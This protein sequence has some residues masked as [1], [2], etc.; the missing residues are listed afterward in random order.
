ML[1]VLDWKESGRLH[2]RF[3]TLP[4]LQ[5]V[6]RT[7]TTSYQN[8]LGSMSNSRVILIVFIRT[9]YL[10]KAGQRDT[11]EYARQQGWRF[12]D[13]ITRYPN[14]WSVARIYV[15]VPLHEVTDTRVLL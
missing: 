15:P 13:G 12:D 10:A 3:L 1:K 14:G 9:V 6:P 7:V 5:V 11:D 4:S 2:Q 8:T